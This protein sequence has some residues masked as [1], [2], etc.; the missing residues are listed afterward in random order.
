MET[1]TMVRRNMTNRNTM[2]VSA[3]IEVIVIENV[4]SVLVNSNAAVE[5]EI[6]DP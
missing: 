3:V 5:A 4:T 1:S 2:A 6:V